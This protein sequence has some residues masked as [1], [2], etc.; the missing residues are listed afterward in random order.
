MIGIEVENGVVDPATGRA[1]PY[2]G[3]VSVESLLLTLQ[4]ELGEN[5]S[6]TMAT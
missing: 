6:S 1:A 4:R 3:A 5:P 2:T